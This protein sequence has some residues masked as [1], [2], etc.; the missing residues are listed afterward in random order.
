M[1][2][3]L[4]STMMALLVMVIL[5]SMMA[6]AALA[7]GYD[8]VH[9]T[10]TLTVNMTATPENGTVPESDRVL[11]TVTPLEGA[12]LPATGEYFVNMAGNGSTGSG[13]VDLTFGEYSKPGIHKY[14]I[15]IGTSLDQADW[16]INDAQKHYVVIITVVN[17]DNYTG[18]DVH[19]GIRNAT[20]DANGNYVYDETETE[21]PDALI[22]EKTYASPR[23]I[24][25]VKRWPDGGAK[26]ITVMLY[27]VVE[28]TE[29]YNGDGK[30]NEKDNRKEIDKVTLSSSYGW[31]H[32]F[33]GLDSRK[34][35]VLDEVDLSGF[36]ES[37][38][39]NKAD[40]LNWVVTI[41]NYK[42]LYQTGQ[43]NWPIP[44]LLCCGS[45]MLLAGMFLMRKKEEPTNE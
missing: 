33:E 17:N 35:Y 19:V 23:T 11:V 15:T 24:T 7:A 27:E 25:L 45:M 37:Y 28:P 36:H 18:L 40:D 12:Q 14:G 30:I 10:L 29:D 4:R 41:T 31:S 22:A 5:V 1:K 39:Y 32:T 6:P 13:R 44:V 34:D 8:P 20:V 3:V 42:S 9:K 38:K 2:R 43:L 16:V 26:P 21:K